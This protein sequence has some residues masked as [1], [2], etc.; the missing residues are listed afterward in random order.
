[1]QSIQKTDKEIVKISDCLPPGDGFE[2]ECR[3]QKLGLGK[4]NYVHERKSVMGKR[5]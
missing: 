2:E 4:G 3:P 1:M 5:G